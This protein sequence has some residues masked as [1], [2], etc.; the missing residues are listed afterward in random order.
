MFLS[1]QVFSFV[2]Y[3]LENNSKSELFHQLI[4]SRVDYPLG[5]LLMIKYAMYDLINKTTGN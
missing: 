5:S 1:F 2:Q 3:Q 4:N